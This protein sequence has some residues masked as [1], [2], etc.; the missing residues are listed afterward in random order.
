[1]QVT[2]TEQMV[3]VMGEPTLR[4]R[5]ADGYCKPPPAAT[6]ERPEWWALQKRR[7]ASSLDFRSFAVSG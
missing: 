1:M 6:P 5:L 2:N 3:L 7:T 4:R